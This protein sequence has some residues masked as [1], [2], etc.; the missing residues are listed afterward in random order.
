MDQRCGLLNAHHDQLGIRVGLGEHIAQRD[1]AALPQ[2]GHRRPVGVIHG[3][4]NCL[5]S[6]RP[7]H[8]GS[9]GCALRLKIN[10]DLDSPRCDGVK[11]I[12]KCLVGLVGCHARW[13]G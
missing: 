4:G 13:D 11:M 7:I 3:A 1:R 8:S 12:N 6:S 9:E 5:V 2:G 10:R